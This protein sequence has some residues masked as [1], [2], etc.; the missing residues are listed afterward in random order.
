M[1]IKE[2]KRDVVIS[3]T[4]NIKAVIHTNTPLTEWDKHT[5]KEVKAFLAAFA[6]GVII[7]GD[8]GA[9]E[10]DGRDIRLR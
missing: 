6:A 3:I 4:H 9:Y 7:S 2:T 5:A 8:G 10:T 1:A